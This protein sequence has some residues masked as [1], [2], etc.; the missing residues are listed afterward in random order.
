MATIGN[1]YLTLADSFLRQGD[2]GVAAIIE[3]LSQI[4]PILEDA[5]AIECNDGAS[6][7][8]TMR[9]VYPSGTWRIHYQGVQPTNA[10]TKPVKDATGFSEAWSELGPNQVEVFG[11]AEAFRLAE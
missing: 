5:L 1:T 4:N 9:T 6:H 2:E 8:T 3:M 11:N 10:T 7:L